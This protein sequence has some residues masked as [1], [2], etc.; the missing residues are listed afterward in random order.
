MA[1][2]RA[3]ASATDAERQT[4]PAAESG[5]LSALLALFTRDN[6][7]GVVAFF[8]LTLAAWYPALDGGMLWDD[9]AHITRPVLQSLDGL[10]R[11]W[12]EIGA[13]QQYYPLLH[14]AFWLEHTVFGDVTFG[15]H[16]I[17]VILH[18]MSALLVVA[19]MRRLGLRGA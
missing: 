15:Y 11:I 7:T 14:S 5:P 18:T 16:L 4:S 2:K 3:R 13:T 10:R 9:N 6:I 19:I 1:K 17:N 8:A 12:F